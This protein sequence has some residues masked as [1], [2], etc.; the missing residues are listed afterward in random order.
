MHADDEDPPLSQL[1]FHY[2]EAA[3]GGDVAKSVDYACRAGMRA[4]A[5][6]A[7]EDAARLFDQ[8][9]Q[10]LDLSDAD[11]RPRRVEVLLERGRAYDAAGDLDQAKTDFEAVRGL[12]AR[13]RRLCRVRPSH[14]G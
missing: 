11:E 13:T 9:L 1:A 5:Q 12:A 10:A 3:Q 14:P 8:A 2:G 6:L 4:L 7:F